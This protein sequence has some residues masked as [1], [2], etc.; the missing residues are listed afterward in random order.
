[1]SAQAILDLSDRRPT[2]RGGTRRAA[3]RPATPLTRNALVADFLALCELDA[4]V[5]SLRAPADPATFAI[6]DETVEHVADYEVVRDGS[7]YLVDVV[8]D[9]DLLN[10][11]LRAASIH[12]ITSAEDR[13]SV[14]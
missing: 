4:D 13:K 8:T 3:K 9:D 5:E 14:V 10:H 2:R 7:A 12:G 6:G 11:P 1:M